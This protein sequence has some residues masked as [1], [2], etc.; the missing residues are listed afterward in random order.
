MEIVTFNVDETFTKFDDEK[1]KCRIEK[2]TY[3]YYFE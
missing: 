2:V 3:F 1:D